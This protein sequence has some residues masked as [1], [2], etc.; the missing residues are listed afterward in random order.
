MTRAGRYVTVLV[1]ALVGATG[2]TATAATLTTTTDGS[3]APYV[4]LPDPDGATGEH[5]PLARLTR[6]QVEA[7]AAAD[8]GI[9]QAVDLRPGSGMRIRFLPDE[10]RWRVSIR[11]RGTVKT[12]ASIE[13]DDATGEVSDRFEL[14]LGDYPSLHTEREAIDAAVADPRVVREARA[15]GGIEQL[16][17]SGDVED[18]CC[19]EVDLFDP[20]RADGDPGKAVIRV[21]VS[22]A[23]LAVTGVWTGIQIPWGMA[24]GDRDGFGDDVNLP[25]VW[26]PLFVLFALVA[27]DWTRLRSWANAD[28]VALMSLGVSHELFQRGMI[29]WSVPLAVPPLAWL[30]VRM[31]WLFARGVP[32]R[33]APRPPRSRA[34]RLALRR[35]PTVALI[36][37]C[38]ALAGV[39]I[40]L[41]L[42]GGN[43]IDVG[44]A[45]VAGARLELAGQAPWGN[46]PDDVDRGDTYGPA[47]Y[48][49]YV[50]ATALLDDPDEHPFGSRIVAAQ[51]TSIAADLGCA[52]LLGLIGWRWISNR[53][54]AL[55]A[56]AWLACP[57]TTWVL[58]SGA[59]D[60]LVAL[61]LLGAFC[62]LRVAWLRGLLVGVATM[63]K[64]APAVALAP[65]LHV[66]STRRVRQAIFAIA[67]FAVAVLAGLAWVVWRLDGTIREDVVLLWERTIAFQ[68]GRDSPFSPWGLYGWPGA[69]K[70]A[71]VVV[72][73]GAVLACVRPRARD[74]WQ[75]AAGVAALLV[76]TQLVTS[77]W[78]YLYIPWFVPFV[79]LVCVAQRERRA[80]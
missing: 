23:S 12:L 11:D 73:L 38:V 19:W 64:F 25:V 29:D 48:L 45:G 16:R 67:G 47:N 70:A 20:D 13:V 27:I 63:V 30:A 39:R 15:W 37:L 4:V 10:R 26:I 5:P 36:I 57:W 41:T 58:A 17:A 50:P 51:W 68:A 72:A 71:F 79:L 56:A 1:V 14:P 9:S 8:S 54:G 59:N 44:Y 53:A 60:S 24:R 49:A 66:G 40:G 43:V 65:M 2:A 75:V 6:T 28:I 32:V 3:G 46:M 77:H 7:I 61:G 80:V 18:G 21:D 34:A 62:A 22:D 76:G 42:D 31:A 33:A 55:L 74:A 69:Q 78:F 52:L 35:V